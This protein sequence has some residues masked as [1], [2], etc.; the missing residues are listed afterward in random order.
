MDLRG[1]IQHMQSINST[2]SKN[3]TR[4]IKELLQLNIRDSLSW[5]SCASYRLGLA[6]LYNNHGLLT[7]RM[8]SSYCWTRRHLS[9][10]IVM[11]KIQDDYETFCLICVQSLKLFHAF[12]PA[13]WCLQLCDASEYT[14]MWSLLL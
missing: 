1:P 3:T 4:E 9:C 11:V 5:S 10:M 7:L 2:Q 13:P 12:P 6:W 8:C 14:S